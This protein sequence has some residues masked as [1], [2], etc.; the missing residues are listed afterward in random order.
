MA[1]PAPLVGPG[2]HHQPGLARLASTNGQRGLHT[3]RIV[4]I[5]Q[6]Q[7][8]PSTDGA[9]KKI[10]R[11]LIFD[12]HPDSLRLI[13]GRGNPSDAHS[14]DPPAMTWLEFGLPCV[15]AVTLLAA[16]FWPLF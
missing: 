3:K 9:D 2:I 13:F 4:V 5:T 8:L 14:T 6:S 15:I 7:R 12:N 11:L 10:Q 1:F 16:I